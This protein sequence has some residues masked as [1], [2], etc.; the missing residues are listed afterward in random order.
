VQLAHQVVQTWMVLPALHVISAQRG[1]YLVPMVKAGPRRA[2][3]VHDTIEYPQTVYPASL[4]VLLRASPGNGVLLI[5]ANHKIAATAP[6]ADLITIVAAELRAK[7]VV[8]ASLQL[9]AQHR[10]QNVSRARQISIRTPPRRAARAKWVF[11]QLVMRSCAPPVLPAK[12]IWT[13]MLRHR[14]RCVQLGFIQLARQPCALHALQ[15]RLTWIRTLQRRVQAVDPALQPRLALCNAPPARP[16]PQTLTKIRLLLAKCASQA[17]LLEVD[18]RR[19]PCVHQVRRTRINRLQ[20]PAWPAA[21]ELGRSKVLFH[22]LPAQQAAQTLTLQPRRRVSSVQWDF[23]R[24]Q[25]QSLVLL[26]E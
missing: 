15:A 2:I 10:A 3:D 20:L 18:P 5:G 17:R 9:Q 7:R 4:L 16:V 22:A 8:A 25:R 1:A 21:Q 6:Q 24:H 14:V 26:A 11:I 23:L 12:L 19:A 13:R